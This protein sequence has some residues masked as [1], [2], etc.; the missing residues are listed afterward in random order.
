MKTLRASCGEMGK[1]GVCSHSQNFF[2]MV[3]SGN[4]YNIAIENGNL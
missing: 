3:P 1:A 4:L 2:L